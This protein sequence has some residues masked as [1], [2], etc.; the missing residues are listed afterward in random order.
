MAAILARAEGRAREVHADPANL[1]LKHLLQA[2]DL[3]LRS[4]GMV[5]EEDTRY[6][7]FLLKLCLEPYPNWWE[8]LQVRYCR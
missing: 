5:P 8:K 1:S 7:R 6:Y 3:V 2:Y 4:K